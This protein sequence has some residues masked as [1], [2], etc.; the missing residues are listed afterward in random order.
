MNLLYSN[1]LPL[2]TDEGQNTII[3]TIKEQITLSDRIDIAV[4]YVSRAS[5]DELEHLAEQNNIKNICLII[6]II[7]AKNTNSIRL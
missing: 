7:R 3:D 4:G 5:L 1:I 2:G 6:L